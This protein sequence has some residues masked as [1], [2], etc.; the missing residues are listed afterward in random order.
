MKKKN[1]GLEGSSYVR[2]R[3]LSMNSPLTGKVDLGLGRE[4]F[5]FFHVAI[6]TPGRNSLLWVVYHKT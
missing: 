5:F 2:L 3:R 4:F 1:T 6:V